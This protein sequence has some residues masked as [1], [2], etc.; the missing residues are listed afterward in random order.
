MLRFR[1]VKT[2]H[3]CNMELKWAACCFFMV[4]H[5]KPLEITSNRVLLTYKCH[6]WRDYRKQR[7]NTL[8]KSSASQQPC[9]SSSL[10]KS[11]MWT[12]YPDVF[13][14]LQKNGIDTIPQN[15]TEASLSTRNRMVDLILSIS[16]EFSLE[17]SFGCMELVLKYKTK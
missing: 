4:S 7:L 2:F 12:S 8:A 17:S 10:L 13:S 9:L 1:F 11:E 16:W 6:D 5:T 14:V 15:L 3:R